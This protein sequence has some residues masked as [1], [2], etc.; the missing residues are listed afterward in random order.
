MKVTQDLA[1][2]MSKLIAINGLSI[3]TVRTDGTVA[4]TP[5]PETPMEKAIT[6]WRDIIAISTYPGGNHIKGHHLVGLKSDGTV[7]AAGNNEYGQC[8]VENWK[9]IV[10]IA[11]GQ[12]HTI[13]LTKDG[14]VVSTQ[15]PSDQDNL[16]VDSDRCHGQTDVEDWK[17]VTYIS[18]SEDFSVGITKSGEILITDPTKYTRDVDTY[19]MQTFKGCVQFNPAC[20][21]GVTKSGLLRSSYCLLPEEVLRR[22]YVMVSGNENT[23]VGLTPNGTV[24]SIWVWDKEIANA[25]TEWRNI[26]A[27]SVNQF[28]VLGLQSD[29]NIV[30]AGTQK[31]MMQIK[32]N[33][34][35]FENY[36]TI[37]EE[38]KNAR[39]SR[40]QKDR[41]ETEKVVK[42]KA[43]T[44]AQVRI[45]EQEV[46]SLFSSFNRKVVS[47]WSRL[48]NY[49]SSAIYPYCPY[50]KKL[51]SF[52]MNE[53]LYIIQS[54]A[55]KY[56]K[57]PQQS[58]I[59]FDWEREA[60]THIAEYESFAEQICNPYA[61]AFESV[62]S[63]GQLRLYQKRLEQ[64]Q[65]SQ[66]RTIGYITND[67]TFVLVYETLRAIH[68]TIREI[69]NDKAAWNSAVAPQN[70]IHVN[71][72]NKW[73]QSFGTV[74]LKGIEALNAKFCV[75]FTKT[76][77]QIVDVDYS[78]YICWKDRSEVIHAEQSIKKKQAE[79]EQRQAN[80][81]QQQLDSMKR[82]I[83]QLNNNLA[84][85]GFAWFGEKK[86]SKQQYEAR[87][88]QL[89]QELAATI[90]KPPL[91]NSTFVYTLNGDP[92]GRINNY[93]HPKWH[94]VYSEKQEAYIVHTPEGRALFNLPNSF[95]ATYGR[96]RKIVGRLETWALTANDNRELHFRFFEE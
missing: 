70:K 34:K 91:P 43:E 22:K 80:L 85:I 90:K 65:T 11:A 67:T 68:E 96:Y 17:D 75:F 3:Y 4:Q 10:A 37:E 7:V 62:S 33:W 71:L 42:E 95:T 64:Q 38:R 48:G 12:Y 56:K 16:F 14:Y 23:I 59:S 24:K 9:N 26:I 39:I 35:A 86:R 69:E 50:F 47:S 36:E 82:E 81:Y 76:A 89:E 72:S 30:V 32:N 79:E 28:S 19:I 8:N 74:F 94:I 5:F 46:H 49:D 13:G 66:S 20:H 45:F 51:D 1:M 88:N 57:L 93:N 63:L 41:L 73:A 83:V 29:G 18:A 78:D 40:V 6:R 58:K 2:E 25:I 60:K 21:S 87:R 55:N 61:S 84:A 15:F 27:I 53:I 54:V 92:L 77:C 44:L 31:Y 52:W